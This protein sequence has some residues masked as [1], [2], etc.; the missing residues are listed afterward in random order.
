M[1][2]YLLVI[3]FSLVGGFFSLIGGIIILYRVK[4]LQE[5]LI[6][7]LSFA[8]GALLATAFLDIFPEAAETGITAVHLFEWAFGAFVVFFL[9]EGF[10][11]QFHHSDDATRFNTAPWLLNMSDGIHNFL[12]GVAIGA[13]FLVNVPL[14]ITTAFAVAMHEI[15]QEIGDFSVA[16][17][18]GWS[19]RS[20]VTVNVLSSLLTV[21]GALLALIFRTTFEA[22]LGAI[23]SVTAGMFLYI[24]ASDL[25]PELYASS[26][27]DKLTHVAALFLCGVA[28][29]AIILHLLPHGA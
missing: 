8:A 5:I 7:L 2:F 24:G 13:A 28:A 25:V 12:D 19:R 29:I 10:F 3:F 15:P 27:R 1:S 11:L 14:G 21:L 22:Y 6:H 16:L 4:N 20:V 17:R 26:R 18:A 9:T 23:L